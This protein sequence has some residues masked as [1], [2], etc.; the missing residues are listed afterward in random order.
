MSP[1]ATFD[2]PERLLM[3]PG[4]SNIHPRVYAALSAPVVGH[5]DPTFLTVMEEAKQLLRSTFQTDNDLTIAISGTGSSGMETC[6]VNAI[7]PSDRVLVCISGVFGVRMR[8]VASRCG[9]EVDVVEVEWGKAI[10]AE[11][12][13]QALATAQYTV[14]A[15]VHAETSTGVLQPLE[16]ISHLVHDHGALFLVDTVTSLGGV[17]LDVDSYGI[18]L[19]YSGTQKC[20]SCPPGLSPVT[21]SPRAMERLAGRRT[22]VQSWYLD[23]TLISQYWGESRV[24]H[25]TAPISMNY[26]LREALLLVA[27][28]GLETRW[29][30]HRHSQAA[31]VRGLEALGL[32]LVVDEA[33]RL[34]AL[35]TVSIPEGIDDARVRSTLLQRFGIEIG[36]GLGAFQGKAWRVGLMGATSTERNVT[37][38]LAALEVT[39]SEQ[40]HKG[41][42]A[43]EAAMSA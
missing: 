26:A 42:G 21:F 33:I 12:V 37:T 1:A 22:P 31:L 25:H 14:V 39:L 29:A 9:A 23:L 28:E 17:R 7:E 41:G 13:S 35:T 40:G 24:Y 16:E 27:E 6:F 8:E 36:G 18:D 5:L 43:V 34:P 20:L 32:D 10:P 4:P 15:I 2:P 3:G 19:C 38:F 30:R 11:M